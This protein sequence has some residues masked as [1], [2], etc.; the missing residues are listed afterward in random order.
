MRENM[1]VFQKHV[2]CDPCPCYV[3]EY[4]GLYN[5]GMNIHDPE[6]VTSLHALGMRLSSMLLHREA[7]V[8]GR[9]FLNYY[10]TI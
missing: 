4:V 5:G 7:I 3:L 8:F 9:A 2:I 10:N 6:H 1:T